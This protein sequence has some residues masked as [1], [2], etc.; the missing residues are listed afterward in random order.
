MLIAVVGVTAVFLPGELAGLRPDVLAALGYATN[1]YLIAQQRSYFEIVGRPPLLQHLWSL[2]V[3][4]QFYL[5]WP[6]LLGLG[7][8]AGRRCMRRLHLWACCLRAC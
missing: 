5:L 8:R 4:E 2:A 1:W 6:L 3:E 7:L